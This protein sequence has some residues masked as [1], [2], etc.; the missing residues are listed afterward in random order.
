MLST[1]SINSTFKVEKGRMSILIE[2]FQ[3]SDKSAK[4]YGKP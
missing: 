3:Q 2:P 1:I 4:P